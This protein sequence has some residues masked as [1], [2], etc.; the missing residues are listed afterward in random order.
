[1]F[2]E[3]RR[4]RVPAHPLPPPRQ[5]RRALESLGITTYSGTRPTN[6][7]GERGTA[8]QYAGFLHALLE[9]IET[10]LRGGELQPQFQQGWMTGY[11]RDVPGLIGALAL[12]LADLAAFAGEGIG[13]IPAAQRQFETAMLALLTAQRG[14]A[15]AAEIATGS[16]TATYAAMELSQQMILNALELGRYADKLD[17]ELGGV[18]GEPDLRVP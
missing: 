13:Q 11:N 10:A 18:A 2:D 3:E 8:A 1:M 7:L 4:A 5:L 14:F 12:Q 15:A 17:A 6:P 9:Q 16:Q